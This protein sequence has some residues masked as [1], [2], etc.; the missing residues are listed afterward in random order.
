MIWIYTLAMWS[1]RTIPH[2]CMAIL[3]HFYHGIN[4]HCAFI[5]NIWNWIDRFS[6]AEDHYLEFFWH[7]HPSFGIRYRFK[8][9]TSL[10][11]YSLRLFET[12]SAA[13]KLFSESL[14]EFP[15]VTWSAIT[16]SSPS[17]TIY[18]V[19]FRNERARKEKHGVKEKKE[20]KWEEEKGREKE[21]EEERK[22]KLVYEI[23]RMKRIFGP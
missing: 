13:L 2:C 23:R 17:Y 1:S 16:S 14:F 4:V 7:S 8:E 6:S 10:I 18:F 22:I 19:Y 21:D 12:F 5:Q 20:K 3:L 9:L 11:L 15:P